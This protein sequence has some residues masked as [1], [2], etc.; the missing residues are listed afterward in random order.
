MEDQS[1][2]TVL[3][4][5]LQVNTEASTK[6][7]LPEKI[8]VEATIP[9]GDH[10][11]DV[12]K[13]VVE[14]R[15][16]QQDDEQPAYRRKIGVIE[17]DIES[18]C[19]E[20]GV[21]G[22]LKHNNIMNMISEYSEEDKQARIYG[23]FQHLTGLVY[24][25]FDRKIHVIRPFIPNPRD[26]CVLELL[27][28]HPRNPDAVMWVAF[29]EKGR[30]FVI[31]EIYLKFGG[32]DEMAMKIRAKA[33][34]YRIIQRRADP[35]AWVEDQHTSMTLSKMLQERGLTYIPASKDRSHGTTLVQN[36]LDFQVVQI[37]KTEEM[38]KPPMLFVFDTCVRTIWEL[39]HWQY[40]EWTGK[41]KERKDPSEK[42]QDKEDHMMEN[43]GRAFLDEVPFVPLP[44]KERQNVQSIPTLDP[45]Q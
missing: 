43:L 38:V 6:T 37:G 27:D 28:P 10:F 2:I 24:K 33:D 11:P 42:P 26:Y 5:P 13:M 35:I 8:S 7:P 9:S 3:N 30:K 19:I 12:G 31:D 14:D 41:S 45:F 25:K 29:D 16:T 36:A 23:K 20:H 34:Q 39:E 15:I 21:R 22:I 32:I 18:N 4:N 1:L 17:A 40:Q 44:K